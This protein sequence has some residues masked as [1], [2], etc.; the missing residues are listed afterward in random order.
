ML[1]LKD[2]VLNLN[3]KIKMLKMIIVRKNMIKIKNKSEKW[4]E[5]IVKE[6]V[7]VNCK[8]K[9]SPLMN[10]WIVMEEIVT[11]FSVRTEMTLSIGVMN[12][13]QIKVKIWEKVYYLKQW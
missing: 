7:K 9:S 13:S 2:G 5:K 6:E 10:Y 3:N 11:N 12:H 4:K 1:K 8:K